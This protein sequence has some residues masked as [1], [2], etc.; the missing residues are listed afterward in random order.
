MPSIL[1]R[2]LCGR[3]PSFSKGKF[4]DEWGSGWAEKKSVQ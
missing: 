1:L 2:G 3:K 4:E